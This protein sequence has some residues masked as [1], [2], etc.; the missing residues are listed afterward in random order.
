MLGNT[1]KR[2]YNKHGFSE[3]TDITFLFISWQSIYIKLKKKSTVY[4]EHDY[5]QKNNL[6][7]FYSNHMTNIF[8]SKGSEKDILIFLKIGG[9]INFMNYDSLKYCQSIVLINNQFATGFPSISHKRITSY[10]YGKKKFS[11]VLCN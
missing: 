3:F 9:D 8:Q 4:N 10:G 7:I 11:V 6:K 2:E 5:K 1:A